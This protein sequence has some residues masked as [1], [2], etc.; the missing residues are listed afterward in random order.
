MDAL[1]DERL[2]ALLL[3]GARAGA[4]A[5]LDL[6]GPLRRLSTRTLSEISRVPR[7]GCVQA[8]RLAATFALAKRLV[9]ERMRPGACF[10]NPRQIFEHFHGVL[11]DKKREIFLVVLLDA[12]HRV[13]REEVVSEGSL[14]S[15]IVHPREVF[16]PAVRESA[17]AVVLVHNHPSGDPRPSEEDVAVTRRLVRASELLGIRVLDHVIVGDGRYTSLRQ[18]GLM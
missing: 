6:H 11:R 14:T 7:I 8:R 16:L 3:G 13:L 10:D 17:G 5:L 12:R 15:S 4:R 1:D 9:G 2:L 18:E